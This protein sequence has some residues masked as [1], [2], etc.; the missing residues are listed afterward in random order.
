MDGIGERVNAGWAN[1]SSNI[2]KDQDGELEMTLAQ[3]ELDPVAAL[4]ATLGPKL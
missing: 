1:D 2:C 4:G 3:F